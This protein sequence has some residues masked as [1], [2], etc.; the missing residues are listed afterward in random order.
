MGGKVWTVPKPVDRK[1]VENRF[2]R[3]VDSFVGALERVPFLITVIVAVPVTIFVVLF[4][5]YSSAAN[6]AVASSVEQEYGYQ[7]V[8]FDV[9]E[10]EAEVKTSDNKV[11][12]LDMLIYKGATI[13]YENEDQLAEKMAKVKNGT[14]PEELYW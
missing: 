14:Y 11:K 4:T 13:L 2:M 3:C 7:E 12:T 6:D 10:A 8:S 1:P 9:G 5:S